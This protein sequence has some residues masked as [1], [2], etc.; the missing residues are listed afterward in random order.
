MRGKGLTYL[1]MIGVIVSLIAFMNTSLVQAQEAFKIG[2]YLS[3]TG[4]AAN[5]GEDA[6]RGID[7]ALQEV[8]SKG[9]IQGKK[10][11]VLYEDS[12]GNPKQA[13][14][15]VQKL[16]NIDKVPII[17]G[18]LFSGEALAVGPIC[19]SS[20]VPTIATQ[21][22]HQDVTKAGEYVFRIA[23]PISMEELVI[24]YA[25]K[26]LGGRRLAGLLFSTDMGRSAAVIAEE[27][28]TKL[29][30]KIVKIE[31]FQ[32]GTT[33]FKTQL[34]KIREEKPDVIE[35][36]GSIKEVAQ[37]IKQMQE[38]GMKLPI[39]GS[40]M[41]R[42]PKLWE[43]TGEAVKG[44]AYATWAPD[45]STKSRYEKFISDYKSK[46][47]FEPKTVT[48]TFA[49]EAT[50]LAVYALDK[51]GDTGEKAEKALLTMKNYPGIT[52]EVT[53]TNGERKARYCVEKIMGPNLFEMTDFCAL[54]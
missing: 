21:A 29:G 7:L 50:K 10:V 47:G 27:V 30:G 13:V 8:N 45:P 1:V 46:Y 28:F 26:V 36:K 34:L 32:E 22:S 44:A 16:I 4:W 23:P 24:E 35:I 12:G 48:A 51:G 25:Y 33:D 17:I 40:N 37:I 18:G 14:S 19:Q 38:L 54:F 6:K 31:F 52:G 39:I 3:L 5:Y 15:A 2:A 41:L 11:E 20:K 53:F 49:Y 9:G 42:E 43:L